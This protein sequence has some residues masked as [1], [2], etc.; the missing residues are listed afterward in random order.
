VQCSRNNVL[1]VAE[2]SERGDY[3]LITFE[4]SVRNL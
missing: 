1:D 2:I 3:S 4:R